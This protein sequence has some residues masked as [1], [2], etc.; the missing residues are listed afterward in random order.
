MRSGRMAPISSVQRHTSTNFFI[1]WAGVSVVLQ[2]LLRSYQRTMR[3]YWKRLTCEK[4]TPFV[5]TTILPLFRSTLITYQHGTNR[6]WNES[7][8]K[9]VVTIGQKEKQA[10]MLVPLIS[11]SGVLLP[12]Q[13]VFVGK[14]DASRPNAKAP[15]Y[16][17]AIKLGFKMVPSKTAT[18]WSTEATME[19]L[20]NKMIAPYFNKTK[21]NLGLPSTQ[22]LI[23]KIDCW[24]VHK[25]AEFWVWMKKNHSTIIVLFVPGGCTG[26][27]QP[28]NVGIQ[29]ILKL[30]VH[31]SAHRN[32]VKE[33]SD[34][35]A[36][37]LWGIKQ[38][39]GLWMQSIKSTRKIWS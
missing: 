38:L 37:G 27:W 33:F 14:A 11:A 18:Y 39:A 22:H 7:G 34:Q 29:R 3:N 24:S 28:L 9:Q 15:A 6:T 19:S 20:V 1:K 36:L 2:R 5:T 4:R 8:V 32:V 31:R 10:F 35:I 12:M 21:E 26:L 25:S 13:V 17:E 23:W 16:D 30:S